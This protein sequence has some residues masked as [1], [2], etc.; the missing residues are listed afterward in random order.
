MHAAGPHVAGPPAQRAPFQPQ[1]DVLIIG[2]RGNGGFA[3]EDTLPSFTSAFATGADAVEIDIRATSDNRVVVMHDPTVDRTTNG[4]G[5]VNVKTLAQIQA[6]DAGS[7][8]GPEFAGTPPP[9]LRDI[10]AATQDAYPAGI[11]YL[12]CKVN[13][14][15]PLIKADAD[16]VGFPYDTVL[17]LGL[18]PGVRSGGYRTTFPNARMIWGEGNWHNGASISSWPGLSSAQK[19]AVVTGMKSRGV[20]GFDFGDN[21]MTS[22]NPV[23]LQEL[24]AAG[25]LVSAYSALHPSR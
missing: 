4:T 7:W 13:G 14:L 10:M 23:T 25:F 1:R 24:R 6:L 16:A 5:S 18:R 17:V 19:H 15:A 11:L 3:P 8:F 12:D 2:H 20:Y 22:L 9:S 21:E